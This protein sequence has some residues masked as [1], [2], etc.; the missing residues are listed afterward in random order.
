MKAD[1]STATA[2]SAPPDDTGLDLDSLAEDP[3]LAALHRDRLLA[4]RAEAEARA[5]AEEVGGGDLDTVGEGECIEACAKAPRAVVHFFHP[6][7][8]S[9]ARLDKHLT[10]LAAAHHTTRFLRTAA[11][12]APFLAV[13][14]GVRVL[15]ALLSF[16]DGACVG[17]C[18]GCDAFGGVANFGAAAVEAELRRQ[19]ALAAP[20]SAAARARVAADADGTGRRAP[21]EHARRTVRRGGGGGRGD[22]SDGSGS[23]ASVS[24]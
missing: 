5:A 11:P 14:L 17:R 22:S 16:A 18:A 8:A 12:D 3:D 6:D 23:D 1:E 20:P 4:L 7:F 13:K 9:C 19:G 15:P 10:A 2:A 21:P 24:E